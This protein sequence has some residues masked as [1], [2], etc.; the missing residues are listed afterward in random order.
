[1]VGGKSQ[2]CRRLMQSPNG[3]DLQF[4]DVDRPR[5]KTWRQIRSEDRRSESYGR[6]TERPPNIGIASTGQDASYRTR[7]VVVP[8]KASLKP[9]RPSVGMA[10]RPA[11]IACRTR[12]R[13]DDRSRTKL[14]WEYP[15]ISL[16]INYHWLLGADMKHLEAHFRCNKAHDLLDAAHSLIA[17]LGPDW[18]KHVIR[19]QAPVCGSINPATSSRRNRVRTRL[20]SAAPVATEL[21][22]S[23]LQASR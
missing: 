22:M 1:M 19:R 2:S 8:N 13:L 12:D 17:Y 20:S 16:I 11:P 3:P 9:C 5:P 6:T 7:S 18:N 14:D 21:E 4:P 23:R 15:L 10:M